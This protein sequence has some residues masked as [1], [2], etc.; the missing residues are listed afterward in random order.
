[1]GNYRLMMFEGLCLPMEDRA[2]STADNSSAMAG[3]GM[4]HTVAC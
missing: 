4:R 3:G 2:M 1:M